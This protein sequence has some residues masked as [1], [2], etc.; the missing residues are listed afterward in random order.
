[1]MSNIYKEIYQFFSGNMLIKFYHPVKDDS[2]I[3]NHALRV[4]YMSAIELGARYV[5]RT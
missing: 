2:T 5:A 3:N 1:M 4:Y